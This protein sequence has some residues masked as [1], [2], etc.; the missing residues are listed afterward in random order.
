MPFAL[1][2]AVFLKLPHVWWYEVWPVQPPIIELLHDFS[3][4]AGLI[5]KYSGGRGK[6]HRKIHGFLA[7][8]QH[9]G[10][11]VVE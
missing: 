1:A 9:A 8:S 5:V 6:A 2:V 3:F 11:D 7:L 4:S 10:V